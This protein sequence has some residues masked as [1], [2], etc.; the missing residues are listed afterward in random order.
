LIA[1]LRGRENLRPAILFTANRNSIAHRPKSRREAVLYVLHPIIRFGEVSHDQLSFCWFGTYRSRPVN[2]RAL[3]FVLSFALF[4]SLPLV[5]REKTDTLV[6]KNGDRLTGE[7]K[8]LDQGVLYVSFD[9]ILG[10][11]SVQWSKVAHLESKQLF[12]V[13][14][15]DGSVYTGTLSTAETEELR[16]VKIE[17]IESSQKQ[18]V[19]PRTQIVKMGE[20]SDRFWER[21]NG[22]INSGIIYS[23]GNN[24][25]QYSLGAEVDYLRERWSANSS[26]NSTLSASSGASSAATR[27]Q[28]NL[29]GMHLLRWNNWFYAGIAS[30]L[31][32]SE[33]DIRL[34][35]NLGAGIGRYLKNTN[36]ASV[37]L[38]GGVAWQ[39]T[40]YKQS[41]L[42]V[43]T[44]NVAAAL[45]AAQVKLFRFNK[46]N[47][48]LTA[49]AFPALSEPGRI[50]FNTNATYYIKIT[51]DLSWNISFYGNWDNQ[52]PANFSGSD[53]GSSSGL[54]YT[55]GLH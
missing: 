39:S 36:H 30:F 52:P 3:V 25:T 5:A 20:T 51:S 41:E 29:E 38:I 54:S 44:Q 6:M 22:D 37:A 28:L 2:V 55:F 50:Y 47:L 40:N 13:K 23:K 14:T 12:I 1:S 16:P 4:F 18:I 19:I 35:S 53:Y 42:P 48:A 34:Q 21:F 49:T 10:T 15:T 33:Q 45:I 32:S 11:S 46:T 43:P 7:I 27:N 26:L 8:G 9:Y 31:Q 17:V 24:N